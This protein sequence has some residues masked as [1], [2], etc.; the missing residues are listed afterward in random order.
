MLL[1]TLKAKTVMHV[2]LVY[3]IMTVLQVNIL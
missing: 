2:L 1:L 3:V